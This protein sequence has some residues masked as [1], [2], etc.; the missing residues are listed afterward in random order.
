MPSGGIPSR[1]FPHPTDDKHHSRTAAGSPGDNKKLPSRSVSFRESDM[2]NYRRGS[3]RTRTRPGS[4]RTTRTDYSRLAGSNVDGKLFFVAQVPRLTGVSFLS[5]QWPST[6][7]RAVC[8]SGAALTVA[9]RLC[10]AAGV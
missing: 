1:H 2:T 4:L 3:K 8:H 7:V 9:R 6:A 10:E 5:F